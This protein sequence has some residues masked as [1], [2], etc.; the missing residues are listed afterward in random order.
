MV[1]KYETTLIDDTLLNQVHVIYGY[2]VLVLIHDTQTFPS[3]CYFFCRTKQVL[4]L[5]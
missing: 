5:T 1:H 3:H 4:Y 2:F